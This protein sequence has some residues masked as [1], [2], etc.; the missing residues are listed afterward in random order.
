MLGR[1]RE[2]VCIFAGPRSSSAKC[3]IENQMKMKKE[4]Y[5]QCMARAAKDKQERLK[6]KEQRKS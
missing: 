6:V 1:C 2:K 3:H 4:L 5:R